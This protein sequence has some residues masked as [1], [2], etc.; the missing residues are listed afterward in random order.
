MISLCEFP[1]TTLN[2]HTKYKHEGMRHPCDQCEHAAT[3]A[4]HLK[5]HIE[6][7]HEG[8]RYLFNQC[9]YAATSK[10]NLK[11]HKN[12]KHKT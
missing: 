1:A 12:S 8:V 10:S 4:G 7:I 2:R 3:T 6:N 5:K 9:M 11:S